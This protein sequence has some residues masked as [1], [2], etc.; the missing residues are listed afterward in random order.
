[1]NIVVVKIQSQFWRIETVSVAMVCFRAPKSHNSWHGNTK[2]IE[3][4]FGAF[5]TVRT[6]NL[7]IKYST[8]ILELSVSQMNRRGRHWRNF[9]IIC[10]LPQ[11]ND[12]PD[13]F[14]VRALL[15]AKTNGGRSLLTDSE[16]LTENLTDRMFINTRARCL[17]P[18]PA[19]KAGSR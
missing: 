3:E 6:P 12:P 9:V 8:V 15:G 14:V 18:G 17:V 4:T 7:N 19:C 10:R 11:R 2:R 1:M 5:W 13:M 16:I